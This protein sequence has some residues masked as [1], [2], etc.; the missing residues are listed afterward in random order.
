MIKVF[1]TISSETVEMRC[2]GID[3]GELASEDF[4]ADYWNRN[5]S[6][7]EVYESYDDEA[8]AMRAWQQ[9]QPGSVY[10][11]RVCVGEVCFYEVLELNKVY[12]DIDEADAGKAYDYIKQNYDISD[13][14]T[15]DVKFSDGEEK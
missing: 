7:L 5:D 4:Q 8:E 12:F 2:T 1:Y 13:L 14:E 11:Q 10:R 15:L 9:E 3:K 6:Y